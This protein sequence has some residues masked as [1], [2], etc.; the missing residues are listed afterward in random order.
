MTNTVKRG[1]GRPAA[2][3]ATNRHAQRTPLPPKAGSAGAE[4]IAEAK[5]GRERYGA[6]LVGDLRKVAKSLGVEGYSRM[7]KGALLAAIVD[8]EHAGAKV[9][10]DGRDRADEAFKIAEKSRGQKLGEILEEWAESADPAKAAPVEPNKID[11]QRQTDLGKMA[12]AAPRT[13]SWQKALAFR[14]SVAA[15]GWSTSVDFA[16]DGEPEDIVEVTAQ[17]SDEH[18]WISWT[19]GAMTLQPMPSYTIVDRTIKL[20]NA[21]A[22]LKYA[23]RDAKTAHDELGKVVSN[24]AFRRKTVTPRKSS[25]PFDIGTATDAEVIAAMA[26]HTVEWYNS[27]SGAMESATLGRDAHRTT[28]QV[29]DGGDRIVKFCCRATGFRA[30]RLSALT[31]VGGYSK[32]VSTSDRKED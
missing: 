1:A 28:I 3:A 27:I 8:A 22:C 30:F 32:T 13:K 21:S 14:Q 15:L 29:L 26:G 5:E 24:K 23:A 2:A 12:E 6:M 25:I 18:L 19:A 10:A 9:A 20:K 16:P 17:R 4:A 31:R 11:E 7:A